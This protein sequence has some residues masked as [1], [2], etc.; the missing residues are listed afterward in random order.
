MGMHTSQRP[1]SEIESKA[2]DFMRF[3][4]CIVSGGNHD[5]PFVINMDQTPVYFSMNTKRMLE[6]V[7]KK[8]IHICTLTNNTKCVTVVVIITTDGTLLPLMLVFKGTLNGRIARTEFPSG[9]YLATHFYKCQDAAWMDKEM[10]IAWVNEV[11]ASYVVTA[12]DH[13]V[14]I[15]ILNMYRCHM[16]ALVG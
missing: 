5:W 12:P 3:M 2:F 1:P 8:T 9:N 10:M 4:R 11:L 16:M 13:I 6:V 15:L 7:G 14:P